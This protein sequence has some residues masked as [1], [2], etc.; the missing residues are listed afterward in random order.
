MFAGNLS[1]W[2]RGPPPRAVQ[3]LNAWIHREPYSHMADCLYWFVVLGFVAPVIAMILPFLLIVR[4]LQQYFGK[5]R[6]IIV[7]Q[8][9]TNV[10]LAV[11]VTGCDSGIGKELALCLATEGFTVF[12]GCL[13]KESLTEFESV[14]M[15]SSMTI[16]PVMLDVTD[17]RQVDSCRDVV[18]TW[19]KNTGVGKRSLHAV[20]NNAGVGIAGYFDWLD[21]SD[22]ESCMN[23]ES[24]N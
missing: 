21:V 13:K 17:P 18:Q 7:P 10:Q 3:T 9:E 6:F 11:V 1:R 8:Q 19:L 22:Y 24:N 15:S 20:V 5:D 23:G 4:L 16:Q 12:V 2:A 14:A